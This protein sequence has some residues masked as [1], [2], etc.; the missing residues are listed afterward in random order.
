MKLG[1][2]LLATFLVAMSGA[3]TTFAAD[4]V[5]PRERALTD[6]RDLRSPLTTERK[7]ALMSLAMLNDP[8]IVNDLGIVDILKAVVLDS[9]DS[10][11]YI[12]CAA[13]Q[14]L[15]DM[16]HNNI[17][18]PG[19]LDMLN[20][21]LQPAKSK[22]KVPP[23]QL[24]LIALRLL[25]TVAMQS[26]SG[27]GASQKMDEAFLILTALLSKKNTPPL[28]Q[29]M[30]AALYECLGTFG[31]RKDARDLLMEGLMR[32]SS[33]EIMD[34]ILRALRTAIV[35][36]S[37]TDRRL[38][39][40]LAD[41]F[42]RSSKDKDR[43]LLVPLLDCLTTMLGNANRLTPRPAASTVYTPAPKLLT[44]VQDMLTT[45]NDQEVT[46]AVH[47]LMRLSTQEPKIGML[48][49]AVASPDTNHPLSYGTLA[50]VN[51]ALVDVLA[52]MGAKTSSVETP[53]AINRR[54]GKEA[55]AIINHM[56]NYLN[57]A[58]KGVPVEIRQNMVIGLGCTPVVFDRNNAVRALVNLLAAEAKSEKPSAILV[59]N[60]E[61]ALTFLTGM[62]PFIT[63]EYEMSKGGKEG[64]E[65]GT[66]T[67]I[68][69]PDIA[70]WEEWLAD[71]KNTDRLK[72][73]K[74][75][76]E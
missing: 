50:T 41:R 32:E 64:A 21:I 65:E 1:F 22:E 24:R 58:A 47:F 27:P 8:A 18:I 28:P 3:S 9:T 2:L 4:K 70:R 7:R 31:V 71:A 56:I 42:M 15:V 48:L 40:V 16:Q 69:T 11:V 72:P 44:V 46:A 62:T 19:L 43:N 61:S 12:R 20:T 66:V 29:S 34:S 38:G 73:G 63:V 57:P 60:I 30:I 13:L 39:D 67:R 49:L 53:E 74:T 59:K 76:F 45:G 75:P 51:M 37:S 25:T 68:E 36:T 54:V 6:L 14:T 33:P 23:F 52:G 35:D 17:Q 55:T 26:A 10:N 5:S